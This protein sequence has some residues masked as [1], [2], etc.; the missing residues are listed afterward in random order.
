MRSRGEAG[1]RR[2]RP[3][4]PEPESSAEFAIDG[5]GVLDLLQQVDRDADEIGVGD[6]ADQ[7]AV[8]YDRQTSDLVFLEEQRR[9][10]EARFLVISPTIWPPPS[11]IGRWW[12]R[13]DC[14]RV[15][16]SARFAVGGRVIRS[17][18]IMASIL[19]M[20]RSF[21]LVLLR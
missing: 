12:I 16:A 8:R 5:F 4:I 7:L 14:M 1:R 15:L 3:G 11:T 10:S 17:V 13:C 18:L 20:A 21:V 9:L 2:I 19:N 6:D